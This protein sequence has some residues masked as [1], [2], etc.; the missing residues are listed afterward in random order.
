MR[1]KVLLLLLQGKQMGTR[2]KSLQQQERF[3]R[4]ALPHKVA[5]KVALNITSCY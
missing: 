4:Q 1:R 3:I 5:H 2:C